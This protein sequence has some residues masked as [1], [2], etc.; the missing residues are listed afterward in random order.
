MVDLSQNVVFRVDG[1]GILGKK[2]KLILRDGDGS[3]LL[4][5]RRKVIE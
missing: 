5:I 3:E 1:C 4:L 2:E